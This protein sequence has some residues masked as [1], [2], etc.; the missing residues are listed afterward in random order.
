M[1]IVYFDTEDKL[2]SS[3]ELI[4]LHNYSDNQ[5]QLQTP[6][7]NIFGTNIYQKHIVDY[8]HLKFPNRFTSE[9]SIDLSSK[10]SLVP[11]EHSENFNIEYII[12]EYKERIEYLN[13]YISSDNDNYIAPNAIDACLNYIQNNWSTNIMLIGNNVI[14]PG[15]P[16]SQRQ[17]LTDENSLNLSGSLWIILCDRTNMIF[18]RDGNIQHVTI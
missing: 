17:N 18:D 3:N 7:G 6:V 2:L 9:I 4:L 5:W 12:K 11:Y 8:L 16:L 15:F 1:S 13:K 10:C 14:Y